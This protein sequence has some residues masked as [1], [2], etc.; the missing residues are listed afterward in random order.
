[1]GG[2]I[3]G[4]GVFVDSFSKGSRE[5]CIGLNG[6]LSMVNGQCP[7]VLAGLY[8]LFSRTFNL[9]IRFIVR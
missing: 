8:L 6:Q 3:G 7:P 4:G 1:M 5:V 9:Q 2:E